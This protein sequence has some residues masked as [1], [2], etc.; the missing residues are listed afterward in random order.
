ME[1]L[2]FPLWRGGDPESQ[3]SRAELGRR[4]GPARLG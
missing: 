2:V 4:S 1:G 3:E